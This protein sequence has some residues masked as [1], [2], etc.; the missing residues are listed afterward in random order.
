MLEKIKSRLSPEQMPA[1]NEALLLL[2]RALPRFVP[3][4]GS[5]DMELDPWRFLHCCS[6][7]AKG[8]QCHEVLRINPTRTLGKPLRAASAHLPGS[9]SLVRQPSQ[10]VLHDDYPLR[11]PAKCAGGNA[12][13]ILRFQGPTPL[14][15]C[16]IFYS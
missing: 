8:V 3:E 5:N 12:G 6:S 13:P 9:L 10:N 14:S 1:F 15:S 7:G 2:T 4:Q 16:K 11:P